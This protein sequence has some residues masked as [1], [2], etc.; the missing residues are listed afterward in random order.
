[1]KKNFTKTVE[2]LNAISEEKETFNE[3][4]RA[5]NEEIQSSNEELQ[6]MN[7]ELETSK[8]E[9]QSTNEELLTLNDEMQNKNTELTLLNSDIS[10]FFSS[11][12]IP[13]II[14]SNDLRIKRFTPM[15]RKVMNLIPT[16]VDRPIG[17]IKLNIDINN[18][19]ELIL[20]V[21]ED[22]MPKEAEVRDKEG[23]WYS[24]RIRPYRTIDNKIDGAIISL[25]DIDVIKR[26]R[27]EVQVLLIMPSLLSRP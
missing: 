26:S 24:V 10:N 23:R 3:E 22:M 7:E 4:L 20:G 13:I 19:E 14:V 8:E 25:I 27:E 16:D 6:S 18:L 1:M 2:R 9:L 5:A 15:A 12:N 21:I 17:D 11:T